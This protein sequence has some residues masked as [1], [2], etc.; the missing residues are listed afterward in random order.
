MMQ[1]T[2]Q[3]ISYQRIRFAHPSKIYRYAVSDRVL[4][5]PTEVRF[6]GSETGG[7]YHARNFVII[8]GF[9]IIGIALATIASIWSSFKVEMQL[10][11][12]SRQQEI[13]G[14]ETLG[15]PAGNDNGSGTEV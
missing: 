3:S 5:G 1:E 4:R 14:G 11:K 15:M 10:Q 12:A 13:D 9:V 2:L 8:I 6:A 7:I